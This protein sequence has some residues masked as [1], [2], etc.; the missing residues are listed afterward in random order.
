MGHFLKLNVSEDNEKVSR[1]RIE[2]KKTLEMF[3][4]TEALK[5]WALSWKSFIVSYSMII[6]KTHH[7]NKL[8]RI[9]DCKCSA[10]DGR[11]MPPLSIPRLSDHHKRASR[12]SVKCQETGRSPVKCCLFSIIWQ[13]ILSHRCFRLLYKTYMRSTEQ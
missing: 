12:Q 2:K 7:V 10:R 6:G 8:M 5:C 13:Q 1:L 9:S 11:A 4:V 3:C